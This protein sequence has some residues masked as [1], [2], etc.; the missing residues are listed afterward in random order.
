MVGNAQR[1]SLNRLLLQCLIK[2]ATGAAN[3]EREYGLASD[4][5]PECFFVGDC[6]GKTLR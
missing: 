5:S 3:L 4:F 1:Y 2:C 6:I